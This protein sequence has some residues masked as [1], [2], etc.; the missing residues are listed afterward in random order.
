MHQLGAE[1]RAGAL[2]QQPLH[3]LRARPRAR[4]RQRRDKRGEVVRRELGQPLDGETL[5][6]VE[7]RG[8]RRGADLARAP[9]RQR[10]RLGAAV[11]D[12]AAKLE[13]L[14]VEEKKEEVKAEEKKEEVKTEEKK[15]EPAASS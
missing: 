3:Q 14:K 6:L 1:V 10:Q 5:E 11:D 12:A 9:R 13:G 7:P 2:L 8:W 15:E 4:R